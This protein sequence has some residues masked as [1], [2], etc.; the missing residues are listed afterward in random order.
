[1][2]P[3]VK[4]GDVVLADFPG[5]IVTKRRPLVVLSSAAYHRQR[6]DVIVGVLTTN[7]GAASADSDYRLLDWQ[8]AGLNS[9]SA[10]RCFLAMMQPATIRVIGHLS[11]RDWQGVRQACQNAI[12]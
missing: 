6:P 8:Q 4:T 5:A 2:H 10:F 12:G 9:P 7:V 11:D 3:M 1:M